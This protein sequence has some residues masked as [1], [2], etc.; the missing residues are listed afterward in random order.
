LL[1]PASLPRVG[2]EIHFDAGSITLGSGPPAEIVLRE[3]SISPVHARITCRHD[4]FLVEDL[5][6]ANGVFVG[7]NRRVA[8]EVGFHQLFRIGRVALEL[9]PDV[10][11]DIPR[12]KPSEPPAVALEPL[13]LVTTERFT[14]SSRMAWLVGTT[15]AVLTAALFGALHLTLGERY[16]ASTQ[17]ASGGI[18]RLVEL[19]PAD[20]SRRV[21]LHPHW[22]L[23]V[24]RAAVTAPLGIT[25]AP[26]GTPRGPKTRLL[27]PSGPAISVEFADPAAARAGVEAMYAGGS[28]G[29]APLLGR[30]RSDPKH[31]DLF[32]ENTPIRL[33]GARETLASLRLSARATMRRVD[34]WNVIYDNGTTLVVESD[35]KA[36][37]LRL[38]GIHRRYQDLGYELRAPEPVV[39]L[40]SGAFDESTWCATSLILPSERD[41]WTQAIL[42]RAYFATV[43]GRQVDCSALTEAGSA[44]L[45]PLFRRLAS[46]EPQ[47][48]SLAEIALR[49]SQAIGLFVRDA[50]T[51][52]HTGK[53]FSYLT[54][55]NVA[56]ARWLSAMHAV[57]LQRSSI[58]RMRPNEQ[59]SMLDA[60]AKLTG[61][62]SLS[63]AWLDYVGHLD[64][65]SHD[66][67][68]VEGSCSD[69]DRIWKPEP[70]ALRARPGC[71]VRP[72]RD[73]TAPRRQRRRWKN[74]GL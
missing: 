60:A 23:S 16:D 55:T 45:E 25:V 13:A 8:C 58:R 37:A 71:S 3:P 62:S 64:R 57:L 54:M 18:T 2:S 73:D 12:A 31:F 63:Q 34:E 4:G 27:V 35:L 5:G 59:L 15:A 72:A 61:Q 69:A 28:E 39:L 1:S 6:S 30:Y 41:A 11:V 70:Y 44:L 20:V 7:P 29:A 52:D 40:D 46:T 32:G 17:T 10:T 19:T 74:A 22:E 14:P 67:L 38:T 43:L 49:S 33:I 9:L 68:A 24:P 26:V 51:E 21:R 56:R 36:F 48:A 66:V 65:P 47:A 50:A 42:E 53:F